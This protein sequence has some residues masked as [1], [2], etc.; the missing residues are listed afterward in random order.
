MQIKSTVACALTLLAVASARPVNNIVNNSNESE[1]AQSIEAQ[2]QAE[3]AQKLQDEQVYGDFSGA[4]EKSFQSLAPLNQQFDINA[5]LEADA[6]VSVDFDGLL[7]EQ[8]TLIEQAQQQKSCLP[9]PY[10]SSS[11]SYGPSSSSSCYSDYSNSGSYC[12]SSF[13]PS[14]SSYGC[15]T[16]SFGCPAPRPAPCPAPCPAPNPVCNT[17]CPLPPAPCAPACPV[18][19]YNPCFASPFGDEFCDYS[20]S[21]SASEIVFNI[22]DYKFDVC[23]ASAFG[24]VAQ[25]RMIGLRYPNNPNA[26]QRTAFINYITGIINNFP[27]TQQR[28]VMSSYLT[29][30]PINV[31]DRKSFN[32]W[33]AA[34]SKNILTEIHFPLG[35]NLQGMFVPVYSKNAKRAVR[36]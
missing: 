15:P 27:C 1:T 29:A 23:G 20:S 35:L 12:S 32:K 4:T 25:L 17:G 2:V 34:F 6:N 7:Q 3:L 36:K 26:A 31:N 28:T 9:R 11:C 14:T 10:P 16:S 19:Q 30:N 21:S 24:V 22:N 8:Q 13:G 33:A 18:P 5:A